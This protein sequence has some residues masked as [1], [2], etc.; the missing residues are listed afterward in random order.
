MLPDQHVDAEC[1][2]ERVQ[3]R[4]PQRGVDDEILFYVFQCLNPR[5]PKGSFTV[6]PGQTHYPFPLTASVSDAHMR[7]ISFDE[8]LNGGVP[9]QTEAAHAS[10]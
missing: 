7:E 8:W 6:V 9:P 4:G 2:H 1:R 3:F 10:V 5:C